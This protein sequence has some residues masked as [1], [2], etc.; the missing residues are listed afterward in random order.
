[1]TKPVS[2]R[3]RIMIRLT[4]KKKREDSEQPYLGICPTYT[5]AGGSEGKESAC[6]AADSRDGSSIPGSGRSPGEG[7]ATSS[8]ILA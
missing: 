3:L 5:A 6:N 2:L 1:M 4:E 8:S 7:M